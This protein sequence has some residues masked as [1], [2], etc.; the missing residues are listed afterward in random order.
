MILRVVGESLPQKEQEG[1]ETVIGLIAVGAVTYMIVWMRGHVRG[2][3]RSLQNE[4]VAALASGS[5]AALVGMAFLAV[6]REGLETAVF[7]LAVFQDTTNPAQRGR[8]RRAR[9]RWSRC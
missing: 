4:V 8:R 7:L 9:P 2:L 5:T 3:K 6:M 1:L